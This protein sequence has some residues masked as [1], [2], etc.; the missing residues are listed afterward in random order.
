MTKRLR[1]ISV[2]FAIGALGG[3]V[4]CGHNKPVP[5]PPTTIT[6]A[7]PPSPVAPRPHQPVAM[8]GDGKYEVLTDIVAGEYKATGPTGSGDGVKCYWARLKDFTGT[9]G[10][11]IAMQYGNH[12]PDVVVIEPSDKG[13]ETRDCGTWTLVAPK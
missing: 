13:F 1:L 7:V 5:T 10:S 12:G 4:G 2:L 8:F 3:P 9:P 11:V 6:R